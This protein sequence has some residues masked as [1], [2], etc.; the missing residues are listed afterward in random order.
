MKLDN[1]QQRQVLLDVINKSPFVGAV[2]EYVTELKQ[3]ISS[4][5]IDLPKRAK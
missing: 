2:S 3:I 1:E 5:E 4:A